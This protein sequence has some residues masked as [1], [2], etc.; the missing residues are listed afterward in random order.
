MVA[1]ANDKPKVIRLRLREAPVAV[2]IGV[3]SALLLLFWYIGN[4]FPQL[5]GGTLLT[6]HLLLLTVGALVAWAGFSGRL[7]KLSPGA[8]ILGAAGIGVALVS[9]L[10]A[11]D[12]ARS[13]VNTWLLTG[14]V[15]CFWLAYSG[16]RAWG[17]SWLSWSLAVGAMGLAVGGLVIDNSFTSYAGFAVSSVPKFTFPLGNKNF[18]ASFF[19]LVWPLF[20]GMAQNQLDGLKKG[21]LYA[22][23]ALSLLCLIGSESRSA[24][25]AAAIQLVLLGVLLAGPMRRAMQGTSRK[26]W[27]IVAAATAVIILA[28]MP[29]VGD[30]ITSLGRIFSDVSGG[31]QIVDNSAAMRLEMWRGA[32]QGFRHYGVTGAGLGSVPSQFP[33]D[34]MQSPRFPDV[35]NPQL[36]STL[37]HV[38]YEL[39][40]GGVLALVGMAGFLIWR[41]IKAVRQSEVPG[42]AIGIAIGLLGY[43]FSLLTDFQWEVPSM[44]VA[45][46]LA[47]ALLVDGSEPENKT[48][49]APTP[50]GQ[51]LAGGLLGVAIL[52]G[53]C[54]M[55]GVKDQAA[56]AYDR[57][58][59]LFQ[60]SDF[61]NGLS[62]W[63]EAVQTDPTFPFY[64]VALGSTIQYLYGDQPLDNNTRPVLE[65][66]RD[67]LADASKTIH[68]TLALIK[69][70]NLRVKL[71]DAKGAIAPL[72]EAVRLTW[73]APVPHYFLAEAYRTLGQRDKAIETYARAV[74]TCPS[75]IWAAIW[76][77]EEG[78]D[79]K[80]PVAKAAL[81][82][83]A[84]DGKS[85]TW[86]RLHMAQ[87][88]I[89][90]GDRQQAESLLTAMISSDPT[91]KAYGPMWLGEAAFQA[92]DWATAAKRFDEARQADPNLSFAFV[93]LGMAKAQMG[94]SSMVKEAFGVL[95]QT[96][97]QNATEEQITHPA[98]MAKAWIPIGFDT[99]KGWTN[100]AYRRAAPEEPF[101]NPITLRPEG[102]FFLNDEKPWPQLPRVTARELAARASLY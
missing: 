6:W 17:R 18:T 51:A 23:G 4:Y 43:G 69:E 100:M 89:M 20:I 94:D 56:L 8:V 42:D 101:P 49:P 88:A 7:A 10:Q 92:K 55:V 46:V 40:I 84:K 64:K 78:K 77:K 90:A 11:A 39:G 32:W 73:Y 54:Y 59:D 60:K 85:D 3:T 98:I 48:E 29:F 9:S 35:V 63:R 24:Y 50:K 33:L 22:G 31:G 68:L 21:I 72:T 96:F 58:Y 66:A 1:N 70:G 45:F 91:A 95:S 2:R 47:A 53:G 26:T 41:T 83:Y 67:L 12:A 102:M 19:L 13:L 74:Y 86:Q 28:A 76:E 61:K 38:L 75:L 99:R 97:G 25:L 71:G 87:L 82:I 44:T 57:G 37:M 34:R 15:G 81:A 65:E 5:Y 93:R 52:A 62:A 36:H 30:R 14:Y 80:V 79:L 27:G 16:T